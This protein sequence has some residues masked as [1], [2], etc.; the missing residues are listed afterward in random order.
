MDNLLVVEQTALHQF[1]LLFVHKTK[2]ILIN[3]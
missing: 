1:I 2:V 3:F